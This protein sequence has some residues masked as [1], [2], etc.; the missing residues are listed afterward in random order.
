MFL[1]FNACGNYVRKIW[2]YILLNLVQENIVNKVIFSKFC[3][4]LTLPTSCTCHS[5][6]NR[7]FWVACTFCVFVYLL[8]YICQSCHF[9][10]LYLW[11][12]EQARYMQLNMFYL[13]QIRTDVCIVHMTY[14]GNKHVNL[15]MCQYSVSGASTWGLLTLLAPWQGCVNNSLLSCQ[16]VV[17]SMLILEDV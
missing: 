5:R 16:R 10:P 15:L 12:Y 11:L 17:P 13:M 2:C 3:C 14:F 9:L 6:C 8:K 1:N 4:V 7:F